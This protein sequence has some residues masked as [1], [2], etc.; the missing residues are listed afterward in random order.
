MLTKRQNFIET[1]TGGNPDR[2]VNQYEYMNVIPVTPYLA[3]H[4]GVAP[5]QENYVDGWGVTW[6]W[7]EGFPGGFPV[8]DEEHIVIKDID[9]WRDYVKAPSLD[10][11]E[12]D[13]ALSMQM[14]SQV[15]KEEQF[16]TAVVFPGILE[17][18]HHLMEIQNCM[19]AFYESPDEMHELIDYLT[20]WEMQYAE[21]L[22]KYMKPEMIFHHDDWGSQQS[23]FLSPEMWREFIKPAYV[24]IYGYF[25]SHG[26]QYIVHHT[27]SY[28]ETLVQDMIDIGID[29]W[30]GTMT[31][32]NIPQIIEKYGDKLTIM[33][34]IDSADIDRPDWTPELAAQV[35]RRSCEKYG[36]KYFI[37]NLTQGMPLSTFPGVCTAN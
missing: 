30:Q 11:T 35:V 22:C 12:E 24:K 5:G 15:D 3:A 29:V 21:Q 32:N 23:T 31:S 7:P 33:G 4:P 6:R 9:N 36:N 34:G 28:A 17:M 13:W 1:V 18:C 14:A 20:D 26:V 25:K 8:H 2:Y 10:Y 27:D 37:P 16:V 19:M